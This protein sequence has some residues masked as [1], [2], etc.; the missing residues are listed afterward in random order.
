MTL[1]EIHHSLLP[2][3]RQIQR[4]GGGLLNPPRAIVIYWI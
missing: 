1:E 2:L 4:E 3:D